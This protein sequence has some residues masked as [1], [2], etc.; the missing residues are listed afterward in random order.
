M[1]RSQP[2]CLRL[3]HRR[4][5]LT[6]V[7]GSVS[8]LL[9]TTFVVSYLRHGTLLTSTSDV[10]RRVIRSAYTNSTPGGVVTDTSGGVVT[11]TSGGVINDDLK[12]EFTESGYLIGNATENL[13]FHSYGGSEVGNRAVTVD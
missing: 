3:T 8:T 6:T 5:R 2:R 13:R 10:I 11:D 1:L 12:T 4:P 9:A 7:L